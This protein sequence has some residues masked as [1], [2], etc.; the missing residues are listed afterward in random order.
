M[1]TEI[2]VRGKDG[3]TLNGQ[4]ALLKRTQYTPPERR[5]PNANAVLRLVNFTKSVVTDL[6]IRATNTRPDL[7]YLGPNVG[8]YRQEVEFDHG[9]AIHGAVR[10][11]I[12]DVRIRS[13][14]GDGIYVAGGD[15]HTSR[16]SRRVTLRD[17]FVRQ[18]GRQGIA[19]NRSRNVVVDRAFIEY[20]RRSAIV[21]EPDTRSETISHVEVRNSSLG[22]NLLAISSAGAGRAN[23]V[24]VHDNIIRRSGLPWVYV[25]STRGLA[26]EGW[27][28]SGNIVKHE[29]GSPMPALAFWNTDD[30]QIT[31]NRMAIAT[32]QSGLA[33]GLWD[34]SNDAVIR[35]NV[36]AGAKADFVSRPPGTVT[37]VG[38][39]NIRSSERPCK[40]K[41]GSTLTGPVAALPD[42]KKPVLRIG[43]TGRAVLAVERRLGVEPSNDH[44]GPRTRAAVRHLQKW[45][46]LPETG[47][48]GPKTWSAM[49]S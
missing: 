10:T 16:W 39:N 28:V 3:L 9:L 31:H 22:S 12:S 5:Y 41:P 40:P 38:R 42:S 8:S 32:K 14:W 15:Q 43:S 37:D 29:L 6:R 21:L 11:R 7:I 30:I 18:N 25:R 20:S 13:V 47:V 1:E 34:G 26:R 19:I 45:H 2:L 23:N 48:V 27:V 17:I 33:V 24:H 46:G 36:F 4:G 35:C 44:F 49:Q